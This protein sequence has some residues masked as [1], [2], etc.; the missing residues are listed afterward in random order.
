MRLFEALT[1]LLAALAA[2]SGVVEELH[3]T[4]WPLLAV[5]V[6]HL[7][8]E[9]PRI[10]LL[11]VR[12]PLPLAA[13]SSVMA[14]RAR[15]MCAQ[16]YLVVPCIFYGTLHER[17][18][19][20]GTDRLSA[21]GAGQIPVWAIVLAEVVLVLAALVAREMPVATFLNVSGPYKQLGLLR[22]VF[23]E[24][25]AERELPVISSPHFPAPEP[26]G[27]HGPF[28]ARL[29]VHCKVFYPAA[30]SALSS[31]STAPSSAGNQSS[32]NQKNASADTTNSGWWS[33]GAE[34]VVGRWRTAN[35][36]AA[37][38]SV[39]SVVFSTMP[40]ARLKAV[41]GVSLSKEQDKF[42]VVWENNES[43]RRGNG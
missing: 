36:Y 13:A 11:G 29:E 9:L 2:L 37:F 28:P 15:P 19:S 27:P 17:Y 12:P 18:A 33:R 3:Y 24:P 1:L 39:P 31:C 26:A 32:N 40:L 7:L 14:D 20:D 25:S 6:C 43:E 5:F 38:V 30:T 4:V 42:P 16:A 34:Y 23:S 41:E 10:Q 35:A 21:G 8:L 22:V